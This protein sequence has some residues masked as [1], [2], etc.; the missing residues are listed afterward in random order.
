MRRRATLLLSVAMGMLV[1]AAPVH[2]WND[3]FEIDGAISWIRGWAIALA[4]GIA[5]LLIVTVAYF[6]WRASRHKSIERPTRS[7]R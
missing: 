6:T 7:K 1:G 5:I 2:A 4:V 3:R